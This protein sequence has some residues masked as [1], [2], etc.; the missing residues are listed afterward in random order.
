MINHFFLVSLFLLLR[1]FDWKGWPSI[2]D[3]V[4]QTRLEKLF[5]HEG[6]FLVFSV[7]PTEHFSSLELKVLVF[8]G[9]GGQHADCLECRLWEVAG[10]FSLYS[11]VTQASGEEDGPVMDL[12]IETVRKVSVI[13]WSGKFTCLFPIF[14]LT[15]EI[16]KLFAFGP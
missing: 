13:C 16:E 9:G 14:I 8:Y 10:G 4:I 1:T 11:L 3:N 2:S 6:N 5:L 7:H 12:I 15:E